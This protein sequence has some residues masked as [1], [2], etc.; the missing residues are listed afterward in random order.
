MGGLGI[1]GV[2]DDRFDGEACAEARSIFL[3]DHMDG[4]GDAA[5]LRI[6][7]SVP[8]C[9][10]GIANHDATKCFLTDFPT[11]LVWHFGEDD[12]PEDAELDASGTDDVRRVR[13]MP[14]VRCH[15]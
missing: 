9:V 13:G 5:S 12:A 14:P 11:Q 6:V 8:G 10:R 1:R 15:H 3:K 4:S 2:G 7:H